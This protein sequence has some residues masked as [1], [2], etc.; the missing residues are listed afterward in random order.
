M[1]R[2]T[3]MIPLAAAE[4]IWSC[5]GEKCTLTTFPEWRGKSS[6]SRSSASDHTYQMRERNK[7]TPKLMYM[8]PVS[9]ATIFFQQTDLAGWIQYKHHA[10]TCT[11]RYHNIIIIITLHSQKEA[12][13]S[14]L[15]QWQWCWLRRCG[16][17]TLSY[18]IRM[19]RWIPTL[20]QSNE[21]NN[22]Q[23]KSRHWCLSQY[24]H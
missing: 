23:P 14:S 6:R 4:R 1:Y 22:W 18:K 20:S 12:C 16:R 10:C 19:S 5:F 9:R 8:T 7:W 3:L 24:M 2:S 15:Q 17:M 13:S 21:P 11:C